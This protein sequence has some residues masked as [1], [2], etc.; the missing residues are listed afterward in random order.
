MHGA[1]AHAMPLGMQ[2]KLTDTTAGIIRSG[3][4]SRQTIK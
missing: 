1:P 3:D 4:A 2:D